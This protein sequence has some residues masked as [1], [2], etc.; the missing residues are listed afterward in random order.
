MPPHHFANAAHPQAA[1]DSSTAM[2][3]CPMHK[4]ADVSAPKMKMVKVQCDLACYGMMA[5]L[6]WHGP[7]SLRQM[8]QVASAFAFPPE[9][10]D[11]HILRIVTP[12][13]NVV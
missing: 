4:S 1:V 5:A 6:E 11:H 10:V 12:P 7:E 9:H 8:Q 3:E 2:V 13:P